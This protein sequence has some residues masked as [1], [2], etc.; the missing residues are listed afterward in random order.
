MLSYRDLQMAIKDYLTA[1]FPDVTVADGKYGQVPALVPPEILIY[2]KPKV[3]LRA[4]QRNEPMFRSA[5]VNLFAC[6][7]GEVEA[8]EAAADAVELLES[9]ESALFDWDEFA[10]GS[11]EHYINTLP[12]QVI[13]DRTTIRYAPD[14]P[15]DFDAFYGDVAVA[16][17]E[18][19]IP[20]AK[21]K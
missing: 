15:P 5:D 6:C 1:K 14:D 4:N 21:A 13:P 9:L 8:E 16:T 12:S 19:I 17:L 20:Y 11:L 2:M 10:Q 3:E 7:G 18:V